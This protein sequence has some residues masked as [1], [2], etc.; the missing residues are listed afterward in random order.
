MG[1]HSYDEKSYRPLMTRFLNDIF[2]V[3]IDNPITK[4]KDGQRI[5][6]FQLV[7]DNIISLFPYDKENYENEMEL[8]I[9]EKTLI[10]KILVQYEELSLEKIKEKLNSIKDNLEKKINIDV[11]A[12]EIKNIDISFEALERSI[13]TH[14]NTLKNKSKDAIIGMINSTKPKNNLELLLTYAKEAT[15]YE[16]VQE[17]I[18][19]DLELL[20]DIISNILLN[21]MMI[22]KPFIDSLNT[23]IEAIRRDLNDDNSDLK[24]FMDIN[25]EILDKE[26]YDRCAGDPE[27]NQKISDIITKIENI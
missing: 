27:L 7:E 2:K 1:I 16:E 26:N 10:K 9:Y 4:N 5:K 25:I 12:K 13:D 21:A 15:T 23:Q 17:E 11:L 8:G 18:N 6:A 24:R 14:K 19:K 3:I 20:E 22:E